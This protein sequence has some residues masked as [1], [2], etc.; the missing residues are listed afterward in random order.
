M[1]FFEFLE[2]DEAYPMAFF[3]VFRMQDSMRKKTLSA[4][5]WYVTDG[6]DFDFLI[7]H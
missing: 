6:L 3:P 1:D 7:P 5:K 4:D 2:I